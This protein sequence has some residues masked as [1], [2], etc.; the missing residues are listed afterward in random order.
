M[1][2]IVFSIVV[3]QLITSFTHRL[4]PPPIQPVGLEKSRMKLIFVVTLLMAA[5]PHTPDPQAAAHSP[6]PRTAQAPEARAAP[7]HHPIEKFIR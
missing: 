5:T 7:H 4:S 3:H 6:N 1:Q 2:V